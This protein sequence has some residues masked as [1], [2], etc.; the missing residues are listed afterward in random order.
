MPT[1][2]RA[3]RGSIFVIASLIGLLVRAVA[4]QVPSTPGG[5]ATLAGVVRD[6]AGNGLRDVEVLIRGTPFAARTNENGEFTISGIAP[7][8]YRAFFRR[9]GFRSVEYNWLPDPGERTEVSV[10]LEPIAQNLDPVVVRAD[11]DK[12]FAAHASIQGIVVDSAGNPIPEAEVSVIGSGGAGMT[13]ANGGFLFKPLAI[14]TYV[15]RVRKFGFAPAT[16]TVELHQ[17]DDR[18]VYIRMRSLAAG[19]DP[20]VVYAQSGLGKNAAWDDLERR[21]RWV[22]ASSRIMGPDE[23]RKFAGLGLDDV[24]K[25]TLLPTTNGSA[26]R[27]PARF[28][29]DAMQAPTSTFSMP[30]DACILLNGTTAL[31]Q[32]LDMYRADEIELLEIY[33]INTELTGTVSKR[34]TSVM[35]APLSILRHPTYYVIWLKGSKPK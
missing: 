17:D 28:R 22:D 31:Q 33:P 35:C 23:L 11:E 2:T 12:R 24:A 6:S 14:G 26:P 15:I 16:L 20:V 30:G 18:E 34:F 9:L 4:A 19:L 5:P 13:R 29:P 32:P 21:R 8:T 3:I 10:G 25:S 27:A 7:G 1:A